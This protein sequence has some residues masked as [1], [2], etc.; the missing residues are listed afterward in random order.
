MKSTNVRGWLLKRHARTFRLGPLCVR[1]PMTVFVVWF[2]LL[3]FD[4]G[5]YLLVGLLAS[6][7]HELGHV[8]C[9]L[10]MFRSAPRLTVSVSGIA[11]DVSWVSLSDGN[12]MILAAAG[13]AMNF[14]AAAWLYRTM[15]VRATVSA[16]AYWAANLL[17][18]GFNLLPIS[19]LDGYQILS[20]GWK[21]WSNKLLFRRE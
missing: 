13:P 11:L 19:P 7:W 2:L 5:G 21:F 6:F 8:L 20:A 4:A 18:G 12:R 3:Y 15:D 16:A 10:A 14:L 9:W 17:I 1:A